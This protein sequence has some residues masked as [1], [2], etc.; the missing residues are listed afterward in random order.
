ML[1]K[2]RLLLTLAA[3]STL[4]SPLSTT[5]AQGTA[6]TYQGV[7]NQG[8]VP[9]NGPTDFTFTLHSAVA[10]AS[11]VGASVV[12]GDLPVTNGLFTT[13]LDFGANFPGAGRFL[14]IAVRPG[15]STGSYTNLSPRQAITAAPYSITAGNISGSLPAGQ[16]TGSVSDARLSPNV[17]LRAGGNSFTGN[18]ALSAGN[19][20]FGDANASIQFPAVSS[21]S[22]PMIQMFT[23]GTQ[24]S[25]RMVIAHSLSYPTWGLQYQDIPDQFDFV[26]NGSPVL[27]VAL[28]SSSVGINASPVASAA[29]TVRGNSTFDGTLTTVGNVGV[30]TANPQQALHV[31]GA[32]LR[33]D[34]AGSEQ[35]FLGGDG[36]G[37]DVELGSFNA[38]VGG[39]ALWNGGLSDYM[40]LYAKGA[41]FNG[42]VGILAT[43]GQPALQLGNVSIPDSL[44]MMRF[45][46]RSGTGFSSRAWE[47]GVPEGDE[48]T[49]GKNYSFVI[50]DLGNGTAPELM[51][52][53]DSGNVGINTTNPG[54]RLD[55]VGGANGNAIQGTVNN[56]GTSGVYGENISSG[57]YGVAGRAS[58]G[59]YGVYGDNANPAGWAG[60]FNGNLYYS[61][62]QS[63]LDVGDNFVATIRAGDLFLG[64]S[65]RRG[66]PGRALVDLTDTLHLN[67]ASDWAHTYIGGDNVSVCSLTIRGGCDIAEPFK[68]SDSEIPKGAV[69]I[70]DENN[71]GHLKMSEQSH[72]RRVAGI[73]S[74]ANG[75]NT[76]VTLTQE[77]VFEN[78][79]N[80]ALSGRVYVQADAGNGAIKPG[81]LLTT[82]DV[83]GHA[84]KVTDHSKA[85]GAILGKAM[86]T[87]EK[88]KGYVLV[89]VTL[90]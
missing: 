64:H 27:S 12:V 75:V 20:T 42:P 22:S 32:Y 5:F 9:V 33:V 41:N 15:N 82:S 31:A 68:M 46:S 21:P 49:F 77:G 61:G 74:G 78:G 45:A 36:F 87:L 24:N 80:V 84:M 62:T 65:S 13:T 63:K 52:R 73:V 47:I 39:V 30:R 14:E 48:N 50:D 58:G 85:Q 88:G 1:T 23:S 70:I 40:H 66:T 4:G 2:I 56:V 28:T 7:L 69:V 60:A 3:L 44:G 59:G 17:A 89:L 86:T 18:Q 55:V 26:R 53:W 34:G 90:Q 38:A 51:I 72:D 57:G 83:P 35:A 6:F 25:N 11:A 19:L 79:Q 10:G 76:G 8:G 81:D 29:L 43:V 54:S 67:F 37:G 16:L 71:P